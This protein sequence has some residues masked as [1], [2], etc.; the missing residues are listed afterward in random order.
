MALV[1]MGCAAKQD[2]GP[3]FCRSYERNYVGQCR[4]HCESQHDDPTSAAASDG[5]EKQCATELADDS[6]F[7]DSCPDDAKRIAAEAR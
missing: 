6:T 5:C 3:E 2:V 7:T 1:T 4:P